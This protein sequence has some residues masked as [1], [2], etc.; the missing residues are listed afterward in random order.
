MSHVS[1]PS[2]TFDFFR[3]NSPS[4]VGDSRKQQG[5]LLPN[6]FASPGTSARV[7]GSFCRIDANPPASPPRNSPYGSSLR[8]VESMYRVCQKW[9]LQQKILFISPSQ[10][11]ILLTFWTNVVFNNT[12][13]KFEI[14]F[15]SQSRPHLKLIPEIDSSNDHLYFSKLGLRLDPLNFQ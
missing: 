10:N 8:I 4:L 9:Y 11:K 14:R 15:L 13:I 5:A 7:Q 12:I 1:T 2:A 3:T 6:D